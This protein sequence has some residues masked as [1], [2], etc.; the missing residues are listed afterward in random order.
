MAQPKIAVWGFLFAAILFLVVA[1]LPLAR[2]GPL[3]ATFL[4]LS[5]VFFVLGAAVA[6]KNRVTD[7]SPPAA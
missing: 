4:A 7:S 1:F 6:K 5:V 3:N 2:G